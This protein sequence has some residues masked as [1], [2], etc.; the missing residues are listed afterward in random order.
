MMS[1]LSVK[2]R[3]GGGIRGQALH[4]PSSFVVLMVHGEAEDVR[5][6]TSKARR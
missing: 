6:E 5:G 2:R 3:F 1:G 4:G